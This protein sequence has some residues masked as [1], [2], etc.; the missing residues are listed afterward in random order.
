M[1]Q[2]IV[3]LMALSFA[4]LVQEGLVYPSSLQL[5]D[6]AA[7]RSVTL[8]AA[9]PRILQAEVITAGEIHDR[10]SDHQAQLSVIRAMH[11]AGRQVAVGLEMFQRRSQTDLNEWISGKLNEKEFEVRFSKNWGMT[12]PLYREIF[13]FCRKERIPM[14]GL[15]VP[16]E[17]TSKVA[18]EGFASLG[19]DDLA[20]LPPITC[21]VGKEYAEI[22]RRAHGH[23]EMSEAAFVRFCEAQLVWDASMA[24]HSEEYLKTN[25]GMSL[26][27]L[28][29]AVHAW[30]A[31]IPDQ[32]RAVNPKRRSLVILPESDQRFRKDAVTVEDCDY[33]YA[34]P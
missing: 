7:Q 5:W 18:R 15:N 34:G 17:V 33:L 29:G 14:V 3:F 8:E 12:W 16:R 10:E 27:V 11:E 25:P 2:S 20:F 26:I 24:V 21:R 30:R 31:G 32:L 28:A 22:M 23:G 4:V 13:L 9:L 19:P 1:K 6:V